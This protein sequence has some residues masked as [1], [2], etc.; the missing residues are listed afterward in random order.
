MLNHVVKQS[1]SK[2]IMTYTGP[3]PCRY[4]PERQGWV[5]MGT[6]IDP[7]AKYPKSEYYLCYECAHKETPCKNNH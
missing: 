5:G 2:G 3:Y 1:T 7:E 4:H 6:V